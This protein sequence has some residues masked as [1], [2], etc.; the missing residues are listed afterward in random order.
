M[1]LTKSQ[2]GSPVCFCQTM[3]L[4]YVER[5]SRTVQLNC[6]QNVFHFVWV[7]L[8]LWKDVFLNVLIRA[9]MGWGPPAEGLNHNRHH[10]GGCLFFC[11]N[12]TIS[13]ASV[14]T[15]S[16]PYL[17][18][19]SDLKLSIDGYCWWE[20]WYGC[21]N[22][23]TEEDDTVT[24][25]VHWRWKIMQVSNLE[26]IDFWG[27]MIWGEG[28]WLVLMWCLALQCTRKQNAHHPLTSFRLWFLASHHTTHVTI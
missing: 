15:K 19:L 9:V 5:T 3:P 1:P 16:N 28:G 4:P 10:Y 13:K 12:C 14:R 2:C 20:W 26:G 21:N 22:R 6:V 18:W 27:E 17:K 25:W 8:C 24:Q 11:D 7:Q 23:L